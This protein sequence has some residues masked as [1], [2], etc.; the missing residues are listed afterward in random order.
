MQRI[1]DGNVEAGVAADPGHFGCLDVLGFRDC[2]CQRLARFLHDHEL[3]AL[4]LFLGRQ[5]GINADAI[6]PR[7]SS[8]ADSD[9]HGLDVGDGQ[10]GCAD[11]LA[12]GARLGDAG[13]EGQVNL[14][15]ELRTVGL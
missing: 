2:P 3:V 7:L 9:E 10:K 12:D 15:E 5:A 11:A 1:G 8:T 14:G 4:A 6:D 13:A